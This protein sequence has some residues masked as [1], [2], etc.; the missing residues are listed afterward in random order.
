METQTLVNV[1]FAIATLVIA[2]VLAVIWVNAACVGGGGGKRGFIDVDRES[3]A[4]DDDYRG[5]P[6][7]SVA[8]AASS[9]SPPPPPSS[10]P[11]PPYY[12]DEI[13][14]LTRPYVATADDDDDEESDRYS[15]RKRRRRECVWPPPPLLQE[16]ECDVLVHYNATAGDVPLSRF[17]TSADHYRADFTSAT[18][19][20]VDTDVGHDRRW[21][22]SR[23]AQLLRYD[24]GENYLSVNRARFA[25][26]ADPVYYRSDAPH[27]SRMCVARLTR[28]SDGVEFYYVQFTQT[29][30]GDGYADRL[31]YT[32]LVE[33]LNT[34]ERFHPDADYVIVGNFNAHGHEAVFRHRLPEHYALCDMRVTPTNIG[35]RGTASPDGLVVS[36]RV[37]EAV[38]YHTELS[39]FNSSTNGALILV[40]G[41]FVRHPLPG[42]GDATQLARHWPLRAMTSAMAER[43]ELGA[44]Y[45]APSTFDPTVHTTDTVM[46]VCSPAT[47]ATTAVDVIPSPD[48]R[49]DDKPPKDKKPKKVVT[50]KQHQQRDK[51]RRQTQHEP[52][53][54]PYGKLF[55]ELQELDDV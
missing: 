28:Y 52:K 13:E 3:L 46:Y 6:D 39:D 51:Q 27:H 54:S 55:E 15:K 20:V 8:A 1:I 12:N 44:Y 22:S 43:G 17:V 23:M 4:S 29:F 19:A 21:T 18:G 10:P 42:G 31:S 26:T 40:A 7:E 34:L 48:T 2:V 33:A 32:A 5:N 14:T 37:Y 9:S 25:I 49:A 53:S 24:G 35:G 16:S 45:D 47:V 30:K 11:P 50:S 36:T 38:E 41:L